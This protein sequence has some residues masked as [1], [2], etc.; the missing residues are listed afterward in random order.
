[1]VQ[2]DAASHAGNPHYSRSPNHDAAVPSVAARAQSQI[3]PS[4]STRPPR[5]GHSSSASPSPHTPGAPSL[6]PLPTSHRISRRPAGHRTFPRKNRT[7][8][9]VLLLPPSFPQLS[10]VARTITGRRGHAAATATFGAVAAGRV[11]STSANT[12]VVD[13]RKRHRRAGRPRE[14]AS[15]SRWIASG[16]ISWR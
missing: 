9:A 14:R 10:A 15:A 2:A 13:V 1:M 11:A 16:I 5:A 3:L 12:P 8:D 7:R 4:S 6:S